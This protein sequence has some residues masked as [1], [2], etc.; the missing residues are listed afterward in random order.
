M[1]RI[2]KI[3]QDEGNVLIMSV[4]IVALLLAT[5]MGYMQ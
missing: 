2:Q 4:V 5:G 1:N 3:N